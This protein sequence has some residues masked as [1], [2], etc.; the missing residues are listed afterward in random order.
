MIFNIKNLFFVVLIS[1]IV[2][3]CTPKDMKINLYTTDIE[4]VKNGE[5]IAIPIE[6]NFSMPGKDEKNILQK[7][8]VIVKKY[9]PADSSF[10]IT[11]GKY[12]NFFVVK[13][14]I[15]LT[16]EVNSNKD[17]GVLTYYPSK[18]GPNYGSIQFNPSKSIISKMNKELRQ[19]DYILSLNLPA[20]N[21]LI[22]IISDS[23]DPFK[24][25]SYSAWVSKKP[26]V[27]YT[28]TLKRREEV[29]LV[30]KGSSSSIYSQIPIF[31]NFETGK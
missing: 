25:N 21:Y 5:T 30:Y 19:V 7:A 2:F 6:L 18:R 10:T 12:S 4:A 14:S 31:F 24:V 1:F 23:K 16:K 22:R 20:T 29:E 27:F 11:K 15:P 17:L 26:F 3:S 8:Q 28:K 13:T 9:L